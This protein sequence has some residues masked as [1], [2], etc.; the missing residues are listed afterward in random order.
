[1]PNLSSFPWIELAV[2]APGQSHYWF[3]DQPSDLHGW[4][5]Q[6]TAHPERGENE[7]GVAETR[8]E[9][10]ELFVL[11]KLAE[12]QAA[13]RSSQVNITV[14]NYSS[15]WAPYSLWVVAVPQHGRRAQPA[16]PTIRSQARVHKQEAEAKPS[17]SE[18]ILI[19]HD[20][21]GNVR[22]AA[23]PHGKA[24]GRA[25]LHVQRGESVL[26]VEDQAA[27][28][29]KLRRAP[30]EYCEKLQLDPAGGGLSFKSK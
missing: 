24:G 15:N 20:K 18:K 25:M 9:V 22:G 4:V 11:C 17:S 6:A 26:Q 14:T 7:S 23:I 8:V 12:T 29:A 10:S 30:R 1:M 28:L 19:V 27:D 5:F 16:I 21:N 13:R 2:L 3:F